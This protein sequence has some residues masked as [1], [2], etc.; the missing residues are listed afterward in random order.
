MDI[1]R[2]FV[3]NWPWRASSLGGTPLL[4]ELQ[5]IDTQ[6]LQPDGLSMGD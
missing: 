3:R 6:I 5:I 4:P 1:N 2:S